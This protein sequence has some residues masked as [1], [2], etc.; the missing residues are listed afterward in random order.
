MG[1]VELGRPYSGVGA[2]VII[3]SEK[4]SSVDQV[5]HETKGEPVRASR[6]ETSFDVLWLKNCSVLSNA[7]IYRGDPNRCYILRD[8]DACVR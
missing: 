6:M 3:S 5:L 7:S 2:C 4:T 1:P 8:T